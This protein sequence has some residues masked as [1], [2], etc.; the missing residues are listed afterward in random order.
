MVAT[1]KGLLLDCSWS[2][3]FTK[4]F[5]QEFFPNLKS[6]LNISFA[7][8]ICYFAFCI[9]LDQYFNGISASCEAFS[10][11][12]LCHFGRFGSIIRLGQKSLQNTSNWAFFRAVC[13][14]GFPQHQETML[15]FRIPKN[16]KQIFNLI[17]SVKRL[18]YDNNLL[19]F[20][21]KL[22]LTF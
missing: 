8:K 3:N 7:I 9:I 19:E 10:L 12:S 11:F 20:A 5:L 4:K 1:R 2:Y 6:V 18:I 17:F 22:K 13:F 16:S 15:W 14:L 21:S